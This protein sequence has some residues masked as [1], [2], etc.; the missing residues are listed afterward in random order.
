MKELI[1]GLIGLSLIAA[2]ITHIVVGISAKAWLFLIFGALMAPVA[3]IHGYATWLGFD[4]L[5]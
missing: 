1:G 2:W 5:N 3:V 4:W